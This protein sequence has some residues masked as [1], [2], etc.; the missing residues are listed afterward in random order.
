MRDGP[1]ES[2]GA[3]IVDHGP[4]LLLCLGGGGRI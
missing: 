2:V 4:E 3:M 1:G